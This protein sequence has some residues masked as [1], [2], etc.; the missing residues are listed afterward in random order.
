MC[1]HCGTATAIAVANAPV[2]SYDLFTDYAA[3]Q[4]VPPAR[5]VECKQCG[6]RAMLTRQAQR[7]AFCDAPVV[8]ELDAKAPGIPPGGVLPFAIDRKQAAGNLARWLRGRW[9]APRDLLARAKRD[10]IDGVYVPCW[11]FDAR[12]T[13]TYVGRRGTHHGSAAGVAFDLLTKSKSV[14]TPHTEW[15]PAGGTVQ[16]ESRDML[17]LATAALP[18][19]LLDQ[20]APWQLAQLR[21]FDDRYLAGFVAE[22]YR[23]EVGAGFEIALAKLDEAICDEIFRQIGGDEQNIDSKQVHWDAVRFRHVLL[24]LWLSAFHY[25]GNVFHLAVNAATGEVLGE[26]PWSVAKIGLLVVALLAAVVA[27]A[28][29]AG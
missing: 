5:E 28:A 16:V 15:S 29:L 12:S 1:D 18:R 25:R 4:V 26:R 7:C 20:L 21:A 27:I 17:V 9:F 6:A 10:Q 14:E 11:L 19:P 13:T 2:A 8:V 24:P 22:R 23:V 3:A